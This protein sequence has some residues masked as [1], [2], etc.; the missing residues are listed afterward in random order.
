M[1]VRWLRSLA[2]FLNGTA[3]RVYHRLRGRLLG[4]TGEQ[5][6]PGLSRAARPDGP[7]D[8]SLTFRDYNE[9]E[10]RQAVSPQCPNRLPAVGSGDDPKPP[11]LRTIRPFQTGFPA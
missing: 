1:V 6:T 7:L 5:S 11:C 10:M 9:T 3:I 2:S 8:G 4:K